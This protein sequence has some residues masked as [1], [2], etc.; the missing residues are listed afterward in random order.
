[1]GNVV[2]HAPSKA[3]FARPLHRYTQAL[4]SAIPT[5]DLSRRHRKNQL[6]TG[7]VANPIDP[8]PG[9]RFMPRCPYASERCREPQALAEVEPGHKVACW[10]VGSGGETA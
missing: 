7:E 4:L 2:E 8:K 10:R 5:T 3:L 1:M 6:L 9:C